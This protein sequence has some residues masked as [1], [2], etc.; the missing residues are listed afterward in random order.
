MAASSKHMKDLHDRVNVFQSRFDISDR[1]AT[2]AYID[3]YIDIHQYI[4]Q[5]T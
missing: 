2:R 3:E 5:K 1:P 4:S